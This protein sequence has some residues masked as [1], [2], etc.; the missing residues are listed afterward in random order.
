[1][2]G[3]K[4]QV[5]VLKARFAIHRNDTENFT[6]NFQSESDEFIRTMTPVKLDTLEGLTGIIMKIVL[7]KHRAELRKQISY[8]IG[9]Q[10][11][12]Q[13]VW[14]RY[15]ADCQTRTNNTNQWLQEYTKGTASN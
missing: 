2:N 9:L 4:Y 10:K 5:E 13:D 15:I 3:I 6:I 8:L 11:K 7:P 12:Q 14:A 1:M